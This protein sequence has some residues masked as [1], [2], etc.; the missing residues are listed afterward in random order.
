MSYIVSTI[1]GSPSGWRVLLGLAFKQ[2]PY[3]A[4]YLQLS[5]MEH[6]SA[7]FLALNSRGKVPILQD[8]DT[9][10]RDSLA[11]LAWLDRKHVERPLF[12]ASPDQAQ[13]IW[14]LTLETAEYLR[15]AFQ[16]VF[17]P[18]LIRGE[19]VSEVS[20]ARLLELEEAASKLQF[21]LNRLDA[22]L[23]NQNFLG[24][25]ARSAVDAVSFPEVQLI[26]RAIDTKRDD[27]DRLGLSDFALAFPR[28]SNWSDRVL[29]LP[30]VSATM[31]VHWA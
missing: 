28:L 26:L 29:S 3:Q 11:I 10:V 31:P 25:S 7:E 21:E 5:D 4:K 6:K 8:G 2:I 19:V 1:S 15:P 20:K 12:G 24:G 18:I 23:E 13:T 27:M 22:L 14:P 16:G 9:I 17:T 30:G